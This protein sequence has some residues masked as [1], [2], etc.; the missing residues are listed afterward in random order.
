MRVETAPG[1]QVRHGETVSVCFEEMRESFY[2]MLYL[3]HASKHSCYAVAC[4][5]SQKRVCSIYCALSRRTFILSAFFFRG[6]A[7][8]NILLT[9]PTS[10]RLSSAAHETLV[11]ALAAP[12]CTATQ[13]QPTGSLWQKFAFGGFRAEIFALAASISILVARYNSLPAFLRILFGTS[14]P[15]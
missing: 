3:V 14:P 9:S 13:P 2:I 1:G 5:F 11:V 7:V 4:K 8:F 15:A 10:L 6:T 12:H